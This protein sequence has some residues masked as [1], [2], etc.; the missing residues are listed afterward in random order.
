MLGGRTAQGPRLLEQSTKALVRPCR[1]S[2]HPAR[3]TRGACTVFR[4]RLSRAAIRRYGVP[5]L[6]HCFVFPFGLC[7]Q[8]AGHFRSA[9]IRL[10]FGKRQQ[11]HRAG[12]ASENIERAAH[13]EAVALLL[14]WRLAKMY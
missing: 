14:Q 4:P 5:E 12:D 9:T 3:A 10:A 11:T 8:L 1:T 2:G 13:L 7:H 6:F